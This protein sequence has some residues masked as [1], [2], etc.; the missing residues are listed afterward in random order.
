MD[1]EQKNT[2]KLEDHADKKYIRFQGLKKASKCSSNRIESLDTNQI[3]SQQFNSRDITRKKGTV[4][5]Y[6]LNYLKDHCIN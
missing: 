4:R 2:L 3:D 1:N 5:I 6:R